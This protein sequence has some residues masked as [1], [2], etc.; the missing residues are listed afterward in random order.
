MERDV[1][2]GVVYECAAV[3]AWCIELDASSLPIALTNTTRGAM[4]RGGA[5]GV[6]VDITFK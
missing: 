1:E 4:Q 6:G 3:Q 2:I 5:A